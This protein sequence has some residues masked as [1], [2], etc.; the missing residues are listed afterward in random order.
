MNKRQ[1]GEVGDVPLQQ[2]ERISVIGANSVAGQA[3]CKAEQ[4]VAHALLR[5]L[6]AEIDDALLDIALLGPADLGHSLAQPGVKKH[7]L[8]YVIATKASNANVGH[9]LNGIV[10]LLLEER[11]GA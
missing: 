1:A 9:R 5:V 11:G 7:L 8:P 10:E 3:V 2:R 4:Q 6:P